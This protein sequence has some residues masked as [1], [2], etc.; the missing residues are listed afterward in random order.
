MDGVL[1]SS[2]AYLIEDYADQPGVKGEALFEEDEFN[3][4]VIDCDNRSLQ[5]AVHSIGD[6]AVQRVLNAYEN[7]QKVNGVRDSRHRVEHIELIQ[8]VDIK[9]FKDLN[10]IASMQP[11]HPPGCDGLPLEPTISKI[12]VN[13][14]NEAYAWRSIKDAGVTVTF[15]TDWPVSNVDPINAISNALNREK[16]SEDTIDQRLS[17]IETLRAYTIEGSYAEFKEH[18]KGILKEGYLADIV[19]LSDRIDL[20]PTDEVSKIEVIKTIIDG[21]IVYSRD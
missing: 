1:D 21:N 6:G 10:V 11:V 7:A 18:S 9:R 12:G 13:R 15:S 5:I 4:L 19:I 2:T 14:Y 20:I 16:W 3:E 8:K 17:L